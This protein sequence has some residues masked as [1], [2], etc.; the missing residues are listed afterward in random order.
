MLL[1][2]RNTFGDLNKEKI[3]NQNI[4]RHVF[5]PFKFF[6]PPKRFWNSAQTNQTSGGNIY[7]KKLAYPNIFKA[8]LFDLIELIYYAAKIENQSL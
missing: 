5:Y 2:E 3:E 6:L 1:C 7:C 4:K 8:L